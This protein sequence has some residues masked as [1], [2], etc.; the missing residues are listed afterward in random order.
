MLPTVSLSRIETPD[1][2]GRCYVY[3]RALITFSIT[4]LLLSIFGQWPHSPRYAE[5]LLVFLIVYAGL[6]LFQFLKY[7]YH[8]TKPGQSAQATLYLDVIALS[9]CA[10]S[11]AQYA[12]L[13]GILSLSTIIAASALLNRLQAL[14]I[15]LTLVITIGT[16]SIYLFL[17]QSVELDKSDFP[18]LINILLI[19]KV[20]YRLQQRNLFS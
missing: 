17:S 15:T 16:P 20:D 6:N 19:K 5:L 11:L 14:L 9:L 3:Y 13:L 18:M 12:L 1:D 10:L 4:I 8:I 7:K 2:L